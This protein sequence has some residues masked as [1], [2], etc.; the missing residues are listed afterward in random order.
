MS[1]HSKW[2][3]I[4]HKKGETDKKKGKV[5]GKHSK[6]IAIA[7]RKGGDPNMNPSLR[8]AIDNA[9]AENMPFDNIDRAIKKGSGEGKDGLQV[10]EVMYEGYG[11]GGTAIMI[12]TLTDN[13]N[14]T[15]ADLKTI[16]SK[17]GGNMGASGSVSYLFKKK[18]LIEVSS[19][20]KSSD[21]IELE[22]IDAGAE[23]IKAGD[24]LIEIYTDPQSLMQVRSSL[25]K[26]GIKAESAALTF[27][28]QTESN[29]NDPA[30][31]KKLFDLID[32]LEENDDVTTVYSNENVSDEV[33]Q[34][35]SD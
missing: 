4:K 32:A 21:E 34:D 20:Q 17:N 33:M 19:S 13:R 26:K 23:D 15:I 2:H 35:I 27:V 10:E 29:I 11:P 6:L 14:R 12:E 28:P 8:A 31:A 7:A 5:F 18:G 1:G 9:R 30:L 22:A 24:E 25:E 3:S 16:M